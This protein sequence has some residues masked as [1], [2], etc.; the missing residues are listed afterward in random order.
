VVAAADWTGSPKILKLKP[1]K[2]EYATEYIRFWAALETVFEPV[3]G[4]DYGKNVL[5]PFFILA[6][7]RCRE[8]SDLGPAARGP[9]VVK[10]APA[11]PLAEGL[12]PPTSA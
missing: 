1:S 10:H 3:P 5:V 7:S 12:A 11:F 2:K 9:H 4:A 8:A 6:V